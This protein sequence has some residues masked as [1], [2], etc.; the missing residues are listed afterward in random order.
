MTKN[1]L[2]PII[3]QEECAEVIQAISKVFRFGLNQVHPQTGVD[4]KS[5]LEVELGQLESMLWELRSHWELDEDKIAA[6]FTSKQRAL[7]K[8]SQYFPNENI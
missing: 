6:A 2:I 5:A 7:N 8:W 4:N 3:T 1:D